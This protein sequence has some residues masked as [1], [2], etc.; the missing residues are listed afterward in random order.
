MCTSR[1]V[2]TLVLALW[3]VKIERKHEAR[4]PGINMK[5][6]SVRT[7]LKQNVIC[8][9]SSL[10][11]C[12]TVVWSSCHKVGREYVMLV[13]SHDYAL[14]VVYNLVCLCTLIQWP[15][16]H[17]NTIIP[18]FPICGLPMLLWK[19]GELRAY[20]FKWEHTCSTCILHRP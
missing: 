14:F 5:R 13:L 6:V 4:K 8:R 3:R 1:S 15:K 16:Q 9:V 2:G 18:T 10:S 7:P 17:N 20:A 19:S 11:P 12:F